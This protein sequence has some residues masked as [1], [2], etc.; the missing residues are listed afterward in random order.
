[1][2]KSGGGIIAGGGEQSTTK[3][4]DKMYLTCIFVPVVVKEPLAAIMPVN[5]QQ[6]AKNPGLKIGR[7]MAPASKVFAGIR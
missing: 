7:D 4:D 6:L 2:N 5:V 1:M 3:K